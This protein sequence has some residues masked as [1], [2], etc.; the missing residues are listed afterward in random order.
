M[1]SLKRIDEVKPKF[2]K[3]TFQ[4]NIMPKLLSIFF[5]IIFWLYVMDQVNPEMIKT[6]T[7]VKVEMMNVENIQ[8]S[9]LVM[10]GEKDFYVNVRLKGRRSE[11]IKVTANDLLITADLEGFQKGVNNIVLNSKIFVDNVSIDSLS[12]NSIKVT[13]DRIIEVS[14]PVKIEFKG[15]I[16]E[17]YTTG[18]LSVAPEEILVKGPETVVNAISSIRGELDLTD[19][20]KQVVKEI[21]VVAVDLDGNIV[22]GVELGRSYVS[23]Q[24]GILRLLNVPVKPVFIGELPE[25]YKL[26]R[27]EVLPTVVTISGDEAIIS[28]TENLLTEEIDLTNLT[29]AT[30]N[31]VVLIIPEGVTAPFAEDTVI[32][33]LYIEQ[34]ITG[35]LEYNATDISIQ[36]SDPEY[37]YEILNA[38]ETVYVAFVSD[39]RNVV[40][41]LEKQDLSLSVDVQGLTEGDHR[42]NLKHTSQETYDSVQLSPDIVTIR[43]TRR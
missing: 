2:N 38:A 13:L 43:V 15:V 41:T 40:E 6:I 12:Q 1:N 4:R 21:P 33:K 7:N 25:G 29:Q 39:G 19:I 18:D 14:K 22:G 23:V 8:S 36:N 10:M 37:Q 28:N 5:A 3:T 32:I 17:N 20:S 26:V 9:G 11:V 24:L 31:E 16:P 27:I 34:V 35:T 30:E 42:I